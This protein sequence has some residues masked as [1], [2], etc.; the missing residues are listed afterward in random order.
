[1]LKNLTITLPE[2]TLRAVRIAAAHDGISMSKWLGRMVERHVD[3]DPEATE[4]ARKEAQREA[5]AQF[6]ALPKASLSLTDENGKAPSK[7]WMNDRE[8]LRRFQ[9]ADLLFGSDEDRSDQALRHVA[10]PASPDWP[11]RPFPTGNK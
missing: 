8:S 5:L 10:E 4:A 11:D 2:K 9:R 3:V 6:L 7:E 1:M